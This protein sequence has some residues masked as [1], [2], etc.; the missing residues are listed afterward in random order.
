MS[1]CTH[2][3]FL[4]LLSEL[5]KHQREDCNELLVAFTGFSSVWAWAPNELHAPPRLPLS[6]TRSTPTPI[7]KSLSP[8]LRFS[9]PLDQGHILKNI[10]DGDIIDFGKL[11]LT[12]CICMISWE[13]G[14]QCNV[15]HKMCG[16]ILKYHRQFHTC[17]RVFWNWKAKFCTA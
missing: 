4:E 7:F 3:L 2:C 14:F 5:K 12:K 15:V 8:D 13:T 6:L 9:H 10:K 17:G 16:W 11:D 1:C